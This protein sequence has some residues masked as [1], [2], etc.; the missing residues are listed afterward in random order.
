MNN[1]VTLDLEVKT[2]PKEKCFKDVETHQNY[3]FIYFD[4]PGLNEGCDKSDYN[5]YKSTTET[6]KCKT[7]S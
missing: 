4:W 1:E 7:K 5:S 6:N 3:N 2:N